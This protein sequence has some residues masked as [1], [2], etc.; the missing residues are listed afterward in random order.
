LVLLFV[1]CVIFGVLAVLC[2]IAIGLV[3]C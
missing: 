3:G 1:D 2:I